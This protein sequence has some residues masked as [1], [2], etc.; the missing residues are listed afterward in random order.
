MQM[1]K[2]KAK[3]RKRSMDQN[4][5]NIESKVD[6][7]TRTLEEAVDA[8]ERSDQDGKF[9]GKK[10]EMRTRKM[11]NVSRDS[12]RGSTAMASKSVPASPLVGRNIPP[13]PLEEGD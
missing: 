3:K 8:F 13:S 7:K 2:S 9:T 1:D 12:R 11:S 4:G 10:E 6:A 5:A